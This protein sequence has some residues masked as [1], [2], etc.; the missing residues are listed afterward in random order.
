MTL[1]YGT[2]I[3]QSPIEKAGEKEL[4]NYETFLKEYGTQLKEIENTLGDTVGDTW[5][6]SIDPITLNVSI[7]LSDLSSSTVAL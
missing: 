3:I 5:D 1:G 4:E 7:Q 6:F 2:A